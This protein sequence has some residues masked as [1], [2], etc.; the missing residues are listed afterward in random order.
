MSKLYI[1]KIVLDN[2]RCFG[3]GFTLD[4]ERD[5]KPILWMTLLGDNATGK[6]TLLRSI[7]IGLCDASSAAG[8]LRE[9]ETGYIRHGANRRGTIEVT[10][11]GN[12]GK[13]KSKITTIIDKIECKEYSFEQ[14]T[15]EVE[16]I[17]FKPWGDIFVC[18]YGLGRG[19]AGT[20]D[21]TGYSAINAVYNLF[22]YS[23]GLQ[24]PELVLRRLGTINKT[25]EVIGL[26]RDLLN[27][28]KPYEIVLKR[29]GIVVD[30]QWGREMPLRDLADGY[31]ATF[32]WMTDFFGW[33]MSYDPNIARIKDVE[34]I[35]LIDAMEE[36]LHPKWQRLVVKQLSDLL[37][38]IQFIVA[39]HSPLIAA[40][41]ADLVSSEIV[42]LRLE[43]RKGVSGDI[44]PSDS[45]RGMRADQVLTSEAFGLGTSRAGQT[46]DYYARFRDLYLRDRLT[47]KEK[48]E[49]L[50][51]RQILKHALPESGETESDLDVQKRL[52]SVLKDL[53]KISGS[54][55]KKR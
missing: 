19:S 50:E 49:L 25:E 55:I 44:I 22:N 32:Q 15:Q 54:G 47:L 52:R 14:L 10:L 7:A 36:H 27:L 53:R 3:E 17:D 46:G 5:G 13:K 26:L 12:D 45:I 29:D 35:V 31:R 2:I 16:P 9:S 33:V 24:N 43:D 20:G 18:A 21:I 48:E 51:L 11:C 40:G 30:G 37:P 1:S 28:K 23:E 6:T 41:T 4:L 42:G 34:G 8:L 38:N 39:T